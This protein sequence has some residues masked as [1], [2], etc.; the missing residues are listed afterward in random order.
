MYKVKGYGYYNN[1]V[2]A[3]FMAKKMNMH[4][5]KIEVNKD[6]DYKK[7]Y[8]RAK[9]YDKF[10]YLVHEEDGSFYDKND[11]DTLNKLKEKYDE[12]VKNE[13]ER[14]K[15]IRYTKERMPLV[16]WCDY[17]EQFTEKCPEYNGKVMFEKITRN[18]N[19]GYIIKD[20]EDYSSKYVDRYYPA[21]Y[22]GNYSLEY[23]QI[24]EKYDGKGDVQRK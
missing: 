1:L 12:T 2:D 5:Y 3:V 16:G 23:N 14:K 17:P 7:L 13:M 9:K 11:M 10:I 19:P 20:Y 21:M 22:I 4:I 18:L 6:T 15:Q 8:L 24:F